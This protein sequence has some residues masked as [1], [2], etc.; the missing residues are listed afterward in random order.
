MGTSYATPLVAGAA[1]LVLEAHPDWSPMQV[2]EALMNTADQADAPDNLYGWGIIDVMAAIAY[3]AK[4]VKGDANNDGLINV[5]DALTVVNFLLG[6][7]EPGP[8]QVWASD[9]NGDGTL[10][11]LDVVCIARIILSPPGSTLKF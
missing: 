2:R 6:L 8:G 9:C 11:V 1:A 3:Q 7:A 5:L 10:N 4:G